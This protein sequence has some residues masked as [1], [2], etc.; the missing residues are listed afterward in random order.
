MLT[1]EQIDE[2]R[3]EDII[4]E[5]AT[6][7]ET[8]LKMTRTPH[9]YPPMGIISTFKYSSYIMDVCCNRI[10]KMAV[11]IQRLR[12]VLK[13]LHLDNKIKNHTN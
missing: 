5:L 13:Q 8:L 4:K 12:S 2:G 1:K 11:D 3:L 9:L 7:T 10:D 6:T